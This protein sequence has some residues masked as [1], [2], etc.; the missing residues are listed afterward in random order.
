MCVCVRTSD[1]R[2]SIATSQHRTFHH[3][4]GICLAR[5]HAPRKHNIRPRSHWMR[6]QIAV[7]KRRDCQHVAAILR[8]CARQQLPTEKAQ[9]GTIVLQLCQVLLQ[10]RVRVWVVVRKEDARA[11][12]Y[13]LRTLKCKRKRVEAGRATPAL[14]AVASHMPVPEVRNVVPNA[15]PPPKPASQS[16][17]AGRNLMS[18]R[19]CV[20]VCVCL[21]ACICA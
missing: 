6:H 10:C 20:C 9:P 11:L 1:E 18:V 5:V 13:L 8:K 14:L 15:S 12:G 2:H 17:R 21:C 16:Q 19:A 7:I 3:V 4:A